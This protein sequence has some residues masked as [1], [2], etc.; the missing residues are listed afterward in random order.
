MTALLTAPPEIRAIGPRYLAAALLFTATA[1]LACAEAL[2]VV[3][4]MPD[5]TPARAGGE[6]VAMQL[7]LPVA[8]ALPP[9]R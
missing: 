8:Y 4:A 7:T 1:A 3:R 2:R 6:P 9:R 5:W